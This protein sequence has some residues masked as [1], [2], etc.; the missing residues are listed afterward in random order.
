MN[1]RRLL[2]AATAAYAAG[3]SALSVL[4]HQAFE[5]GRFDLGNMVQA[6][7]STAHG[8]PLGITTLHGTQTVRLAA[9]VDPILVLFAP[10]WW[11]W[12]SPSLLLVVQAVAIALGALPVFWL[13]RKQLGSERTALG[14][15]LAYLLYPAT[16]WLTLSEF[17]P[18]ALACPLLLYAFW[19]LDEDRL[20]PFAVAAV[21][22]SATKE[23]VPLVVGG[24]GVWYAFARHHGAIGTAIAA[25]G[26]A[27]TGFAV[28]VVI[29]RFNDGSEP[30]FYGRYS[31]VGGSARGI[32]ETALTDPLTILSVAF[33]AR[34]IG[35]LVSLLLPLA[36]LPL[37]APLAL[38]AAVPE[39]ALNLLSS[40]RTQT[41]IHFHY[42]AAVTP[43]LFAAAVL[44]AKRIRRELGGTIVV[45]ALVANFALGA[46][47]VWS[48]FPGGE[49]LQSGSYDITEHD[50]VAARALRVIPDDAVVTASN[51]LGAHLS[52]RR[53][54]LSFPRLDDADWVAADERSP[55]Y[56]DRFAPVP[57][58]NALA[59]LRRD[60]GWRLVFEEDGILVFRRRSGRG[61]AAF[62][63]LP[64]RG[65][66]RADSR[67]ASYYSGIVCGS[68]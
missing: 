65:S 51:S 20:V 29:P 34:G 54:I 5:T 41:S 14:F 22:A 63:D 64:R 45:F 52:A 67:L 24:L 23:E 39:L 1:E 68:R 15:A 46:I 26:V 50:R 6:V 40:T 27:W 49:D 9:H 7:W 58:A 61:A 28:G 35:Y 43:I 13:A 60:D 55:G 11:L 62:R 8:D 59:R 12:P 31:E 17:H 56:A 4:R 36:L 57:Y 37:L 21:L 10:M 3:F 42:T 38:V 33:D 2:A 25:A 48:L 32:A 18:V 16:Q 44:G 66:A 53:R 47:P 30:S 19:Y